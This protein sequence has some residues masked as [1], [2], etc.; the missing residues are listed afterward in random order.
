[1]FSSDYI[2]I[3]I[4]IYMCVCRYGYTLLYVRNLQ[5]SVHVYTYIYIYGVYVYS[6]MHACMCLLGFYILTTSKV[7]RRRVLTCDSKHSYIQIMQTAR[8]TISINFISHRFNSARIRTP[9]LR[10]FFYSDNHEHDLLVHSTGYSVQWM[11]RWLMVYFR[12]ILILYLMLN[13]WTYK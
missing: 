9:D 6:C 10:P 8:L 2:Y 3:Y 11:V 13:L 1:M 5:V 12:C 4:Y 7:L